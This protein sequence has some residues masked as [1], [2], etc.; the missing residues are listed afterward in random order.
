M[1][2]Q[3]I[4]WILVIVSS[5]LIVGVGC[6]EGEVPEQ[7]DEIREVG[8][9]EIPD[10]D[11]GGDDDNGNDDN[12]D[13]GNG[14]S[15]L[16][17]DVDCSG[18][19]HCDPETGDCVE[20]VSDTDCDGDDVCDDQTNTCERDDTGEA[21]TGDDDCTGD[22]V[23]DDDNC[24]ECADDGDCPDDD[25]ECDTAINQC[26]FT[27]ECF[28]DTD[29]DGDDVCHDSSCVDC[30][31]DGDCPDG[32]FQCDTATNQC[33]FTG[34]CTVDTDCDG[35]LVCDDDTCVECVDDG[36]CPD[37]DFQCDTAANQCEFTGEC[38]DT[39]DCDGTD[40][41]DPALQECVACLDDDDCDGDLVCDD[42]GPSC[43]ECLDDDDCTD[44]TCDT[45]YGVCEPDDDDCCTFTQE[46]IPTDV[47]SFSDHGF[48]VAIGDDGEPIVAV[49]DHDSPMLHVVERD[50]GSWSTQMVMDL[51]TYSIDSLVPLDM[52]LGPDGEPHIVI[53]GMYS[54][55]YIQGD[56]GS[57]NFQILHELDDGMFWSAAIAAGDDGH[58][59][60]IGGKSTG[61]DNSF[62][63]ERFD[64]GTSVTTQ[65]HVLEYTDA[66]VDGI[67]MDVASNDEPRMLMTMG[68]DDVQ[69]LSPDDSTATT[70][71]GGSIGTST[72]DFAALALD[73][74][75]D[76][77]SILRPGISDELE[78]WRFAGTGFDDWDNWDTEMLATSPA[79][80]PRIT[81]DATDSPHVCYAA[82][83]G[84]T[85]ELVYGYRSDGQ[86]Q[87]HHLD[88]LST[89][90]ASRIAVD[91]TTPHIVGRFD[92]GDTLRYF[93][94]E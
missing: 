93:V 90:N 51:S 50:A 12:G 3:W 15:E 5:L 1:Q 33:E 52:T 78:S 81:L 84:S 54:L 6:A 30:V 38:L 34:E 88:A 64:D 36:D 28:D 40:V 80:K 76:P 41:C 62:Y 68:G 63:Y 35:D 32:D 44:G 29:C 20:C 47:N 66:T 65:Q 86:W 53:A 13:D 45:T 79:S 10:D 24:V 70:W 56:S 48:D 7:E 31:D 17:D 49:V 22:L 61:A 57:L 75:D 46:E 16:C 74:D 87:Q 14:D 23:C 2:K 11:N 43:L 9:H 73:N 42:T 8:N 21:C 71:D 60:V 82:E 94:L 27:G 4:R 89:A 92:A 67:D 85:Y 72:T 69:I 39:S 19:E 58:I 25:F 83:D 77:W 26:E 91:T 37:G 59:H 55:L 18:D